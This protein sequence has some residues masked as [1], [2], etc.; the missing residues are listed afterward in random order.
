[1]PV[2]VT[3][4]SVGANALSDN[5][6][7]GELYEYLPT[8]GPLSLFVTGSATGLRVSFSVGGAIQAEDAVVNTQNRI[9]VVPDDLLLRAG[10]RRGERLIL[11]FR[12][13]TAGALTARALVQI[14]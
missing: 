9:P 6:L 2:M 14:G 3:E 11:R 13:T 4:D 7:A 12:N 10:G 1:M 8:T 5:V